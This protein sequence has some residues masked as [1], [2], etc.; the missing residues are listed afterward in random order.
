MF[1]R[2]KV[3]NADQ[4]LVSVELQLTDGTGLIGKIAM[5]SGRGFME[6]LNGAS[7]FLEFESLEGDRRFIAKSTI[8]AVKLISVPRGVNLNQRLRDLDG[9]DPY[10]ILGI[11]R[12][13]TWDETRTTF[14]RLAKV[15]HPDRYATAELPDEVKTYLSAM[16]RRVNAAYAALETAHAQRKHFAS[17]RQEPIFTSSAR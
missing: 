2:N 16:A 10:A 3:D 9:F 1:E 8:G 15:Y 14:H 17:L 4:G 5:P 11:E 6:F 12:T 13:A 7:N